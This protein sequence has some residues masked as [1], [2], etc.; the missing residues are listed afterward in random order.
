MMISQMISFL[1]TAFQNKQ[2]R[3]KRLFNLKLKKI[4]VSSSH[5][6]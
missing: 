2:Q 3:K 5:F 6:L 1:V 4:I